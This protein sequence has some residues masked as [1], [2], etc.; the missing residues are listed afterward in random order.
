MLRFRHIIHPIFETPSIKVMIQMFRSIFSFFNRSVSNIPSAMSRHVATYNLFV[1]AVFIVMPAILLLTVPVKAQFAGGEGAKEDP[2]QIETIEQLQTIADMLYLDKHFIQIADIDASDTE[3][4]NEGKG[5]EPIGSSSD[6]SFTGSYDGNGYEISGLHIDRPDRDGV[7]LF[8]F[9]YR[10]SATGSIS[11]LYLHQINIVGGDMVG[12]L[13][14]YISWPGEVSGV[15]VSGN[16]YG[17]SYVGGLAGIGGGLI[18]NSHVTVD[19]TGNNKVGGLAGFG[20]SSNSIATGD[21]TGNSRVGGLVG[22]G[23]GVQNSVATGNV[24]GD[25]YVGGLAGSVGFVHASYATGDVFGNRYVGGLVGFLVPHPEEWEVNVV[26][27][28]YAT[29][30]VSGGEYTGG[31]I[32]RNLGQQIIACYWDVLSSGTEHGVGFASKASGKNKVPLEYPPTIN[33]VTGLETEQMQGQNAWIYMHK[34]DFDQTWQ[35]TE[36]YPV[37]YW[38]EPDDPVANP[39]LSMITVSIQEYDFWK[40]EIGD[41]LI[42]TFTIKNKGNTNMHLEIYI[43]VSNQTDDMGFRIIEGKGTHVLEPESTHV[44]EVAFV[45][46]DIR[47]YSAWMLVDHD[48]VNEESPVEILLGGTGVQVISAVRCIGASPGEMVF[49][50]DV[51]YEVVD[52]GLL[53]Q[54]RIEGADLTRVCT[55]PVTDMSGLFSNETEFNQPIVAWDVSNVTDMRSMFS[56]AAGFNRSIKG[57]DVSNVTNMSEMF[58][59]AESF[60]QPIGDWDVSNVTNMFRMF[61]SAGSFNQPIGAWDVSNV[62]DMRSMFSSA[63]S[64]NQPIGDWDVN[65]VTNM[66]WMFFRADSFNQPIGEWDVSNVTNMFRMFSSAG[67]FNQPIG[68]WDV[69]QVTDMEWMFSSASSFNQ[70]L[71]EWDMSSVSRMGAMFMDASSFNQP[72]GEWDVS[73]VTTMTFMFSGAAD[74]DQPIEDWETSSVTNMRFMFSSAGSFNQPVGNWDVSSVIM[75]D[76]M[77]TD[78]TSFNQD[79]S[80]WCVDQITSEPT[81]F[82]KNSPLIPE[83]KPIWGTCPETTSTEP[84]SEILTEFTLDQNYP[85]P[86]NPSTLIRFALPEKVHVN[87]TLYNLL[88]QKIATLVN[89]TRPPGR[90]EV[91]FDATG[92]S[93]GTFIYRLEAG[94]Y[95]ETRSMI[96]LK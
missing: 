64:F 23:Y 90:H 1:A 24:S 85:N 92:L 77:F 6:H 74:F 71:G 80:S 33:D 63:G 35:L 18:S 43:P 19:V 93:S 42:N 62:T 47:D 78:A 30:E 51:E 26:S 32:G 50:E 96:F 4:W 95:M 5:F 53:F 45:P 48:A 40:V 7:G 91:T 41:S 86:F 38:Q 14:G 16:I 10:R 87:L 9:A 59:G 79:V 72:I 39:E 25:S 44:V 21:V 76:G 56:G 70:P 65:N 28:S 68:N 17:D 89:E 75:M 60:N 15:S 29:G 13:I 31:F 46:E 69:N 88:G 66:R 2:Y 37:L 83:Y 27:Q 84:I 67:S 52:R 54:R 3:N 57:W 49:V 61:S 81:D 22:E 82:S 58:R 94:E 20:G 11:D 34:F 73:N 55:T 12:G 36:G 8:G